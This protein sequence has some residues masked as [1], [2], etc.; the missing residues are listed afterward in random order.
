VKRK[1]ELHRHHKAFLAFA[2]ILFAG[3][4]AGSWFTW[5]ECGDLEA[6]AAAITDQVGAMKKKV[7]GIDDLETEVIVL[8]ENVAGYIRILPNDAEVNEFFRTINAFQRDSGITIDNLEPQ[9][10]RTKL[11]T[12]QVF[13]RAE[14]KMKFTATFRQLLKFIERL[15]NHERFVSISEVKVKAGKRDEKQPGEPVHD[16]DLSLVTYVYLGDAAGKSVSIPAFERKRDRMLDRIAE[17]REDLALERFQLLSDAMRRDPLVDPR[18]RRDESGRNAPGIEDQ[19]AL[20][21]R[22]TARLDEANQLLD[23]MAETKNVIRE[24]ELRVQAINLVAELQGQADEVGVRGGFT[25]ALL[26]RDWEKKVLPDLAKLRERVGGQ[27][28]P[29]GLAGRPTRVRQLE[30]ALAT[31]EAH[32]EAGDYA[33][34]VKDFELVRISGGGNGADPR[35]VALEGQME[36][37]YLAAQTAVEFGKKQL[38]VTGL[39]VEQGA[40]SVAIINHV[41]YRAGE[42]VEDDLVLLE[43]HEDRLVFE[44]RGVPLTY[45]L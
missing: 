9:R 3:S 13:D 25:D 10:A 39:V 40:E 17:A 19:R 4:A 31:M 15:E 43:I 11:Q 12:S 23:L 33:A 20:F 24:M 26:R 34:C 42:A 22:V 32:Y 5:K 1:L 45:D 18:R 41:V 29:E 14:Y 8:R 44:Y 6:E 35:V 16:V 30:Q 28:A 27:A 37:Y 21:N 2:G 38:D 7:A 36:R